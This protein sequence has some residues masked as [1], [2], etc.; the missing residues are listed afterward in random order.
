MSQELLYWQALNRAMDIEMAADDSVFTL[1]EDVGLFG[2][3]YRV[4]EGLV[5]QIWRMARS[6][7]PDLREQLHRS[8]RR[9]GALG[10]AAGGRDHDHQLHAS[11]ARLHHQRRCQDPV[12]VGWTVQ[13]AAGRARARRCG[14]P[15]GGATR[16]KPGAHLDECPGPAHRRA[17]NAA[18]CVLAASPGHRQRRA[19]HSPG[20]RAALLQQGAGG[21]AGRSAADASSDCTPRGTRSD[22]RELFASCGAVAGGGRGTRQGRNRGGGHR[23]AQPEAHRLG[24]LRQ[25]AR[26]DA[27]IVGR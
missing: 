14:A 17:R 24:Y 3:S 22:D 4:T 16:A 6:R 27:P 13:D 21:P 19:H 26:P 25:L 12:H 15:V 7:Y 1:G 10:H 8:W 23:Y 20:A 5:R 18:G 2:G 9:R 11:G